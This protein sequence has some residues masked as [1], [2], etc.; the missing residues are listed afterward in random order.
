M[1]WTAAPLALG[2]AGSVLLLTVIAWPIGAI[3][4]RRHRY[5]LPL[6]PGERRAR[7]LT[8]LAAVLALVAAVAWV[9]GGMLIQLAVNPSPTLFRIPQVLSVLAILGVV[10][11]TVQLVRAIARRAGFGAVAWHVLVLLSLGAF[12]V[13]CLVL[14]LLSLSATY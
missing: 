7:L 5:E 10:P 12:G 8:H 4:R 1:L 14:N 2:L 13:S 3:V 6:G 9:A 11:A